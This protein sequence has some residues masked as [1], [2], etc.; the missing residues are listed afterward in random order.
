MKI[1]FILNQFL[2]VFEKLPGINIQQVI[3]V[4]NKK[5]ILTPKVGTRLIRNYFLKINDLSLGD[6]WNY[7]EYHTSKSLQSSLDTENIY[8]ILRDPLERL[9]SC[10]KQKIYKFRDKSF[11]SYF[12]MYFPLIKRDMDFLSFLKAVK[13]I[14]P[15][16]SEKHFRPIS[17]TVDM[18]HKNLIKVNIK[19]LNA[20]LNTQGHAN[21]TP[22]VKIPIDCKDY[23]IK[24]LLCR[25]KNDSN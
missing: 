24:N 19:D 22:M 14:P 20:F 4:Q 25:Y 15:F 10:W 2:R 1:R 23:F 5:F 3:L 12:W 7:I 11:L 18:S 13:K 16:L 8:I 9:H 17:E 21:I 6:E